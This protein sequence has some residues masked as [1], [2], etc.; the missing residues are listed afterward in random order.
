MF[1][2]VIKDI[3]RF[4]VSL[5][6]VFLVL[7]F[8]F[9]AHAEL[10]EINTVWSEFPLSV[11]E[12]DFHDD[13]VTFTFTDGSRKTLLFDQWIKMLD[14][15]IGRLS[16]FINNPSNGNFAKLT[17]DEKLEVLIGALVKDPREY[18]NDER[19]YRVEI[20]NEEF[21]TAEYFNKFSSVAFPYLNSMS[22]A[23]QQ[24]V[25]TA[26]FKNFM[27]RGEEETL[28]AAAELYNSL[29][30]KFDLNLIKTDICDYAQMT[31]FEKTR[32]YIEK[33]KIFADTL[34][35]P[36]KFAT[37]SCE[38]EG[39]VSMNLFDILNSYRDPSKKLSSASQGLVTLSTQVKWNGCTMQQ[40]KILARSIEN[41]FLQFP[42]SQMFWVMEQEGACRI[43]ILVTKL[44]QGNFKM[45]I[46]KAQPEGHGVT[47]VLFNT[48]RELVVGIG[49]QNQSH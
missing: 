33:I 3:C 8:C 36:G 31:R 1:R 17:H 30:D 42:K 43:N 34:K 19:L 21:F 20:D 10:R 24:L 29:G 45:E 26:A 25:L 41:H 46:N 48:L 5:A 13:G 4:W 39:D 16:G 15:R 22:P 38:F 12:W 6:C 40:R 37:L 28:K 32:G 35:S 49:A 44:P 2:A 14:D 27:S 7:F 9:V 18:F 23:D 11:N 47:A